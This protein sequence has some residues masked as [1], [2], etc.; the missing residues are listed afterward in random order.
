[1]QGQDALVKGWEEPLKP[2]KARKVEPLM[3]VVKLGFGHINPLFFTCKA[4]YSVLLHVI[5][6][7]YMPNRNRTGP[8]GTFKDCVPTKNFDWGNRPRLGR[9]RGRGS[10]RGRNRR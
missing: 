4:L 3:P 2:V 1:M 6:G 7:E 8:R 5:R 10:G 9:G